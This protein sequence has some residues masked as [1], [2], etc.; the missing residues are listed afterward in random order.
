VGGGVSDPRETAV[1]WRQSVHGLVSSRIEPWEHGTLVR[2]P[3]L[4]R[5]YEFN[6]VRLEMSDPGL[7][8]EALSE[9]AEDWLGD[10]EHRRVEVF[11]QAAGER[12]RPGFE[13]LGWR[14]E[15]L[16][17]LHRGLPGPEAVAPPGIE[18]RSDSFVAS[19]PLRAAWRGETPYDDGPEFVFVEERA[20]ALR[21][22]VTAIAYD[23]ETPVAF[24]AASTRGPTTEI[25]LVFAMPERRGGGI[26][27]AVVCT[28]LT[29]ATA[30]GASEA[31]IEA[32]DEGDAK[33]LYE[34]LGFRTVW[35]RHVFTRL[36]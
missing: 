34:R 2:S 14:A 23:G 22:T 1:R 36:P 35:V 25:E 15:R 21:G 30:A 16:A 5:F 18:L 12:L 20:A 8:A 11:D 31:L 7:S 3:E 33:R 26:G 9:T 27:G 4:P 17:F 19:R 29:D 28:A 24:A 13:A 10:L 6:V 32:D